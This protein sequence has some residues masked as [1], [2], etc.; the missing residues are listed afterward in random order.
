VWWPF[1]N[2][3]RCNVRLELVAERP[4]LL[5]RPRL[6]EDDVIDFE[7]EIR[8]LAAAQVPTVASAAAVRAVRI[9]A[10]T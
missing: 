5:H 3:C 10:L 7:G 1:L 2:E 9:R 4:Q 8:V 6:L